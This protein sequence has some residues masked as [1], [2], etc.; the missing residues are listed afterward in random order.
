MGTKPGKGYS[1][2]VRKRC[3]RC[4]KVRAYRFCLNFYYPERKIWQRITP[5]GPKVCHI[6]IER[7]G[8]EDEPKNN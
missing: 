8:L 1:E 3:P 7:L 4:K 5:D 6:C 2:I